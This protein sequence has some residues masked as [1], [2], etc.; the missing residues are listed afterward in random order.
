MFISQI[1]THGFYL[2]SHKPTPTQASGYPGHESAEQPELMSHSN[3]FCWEKV[4]SLA[5]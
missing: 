5:M 3:G 4:P 2:T 1:F